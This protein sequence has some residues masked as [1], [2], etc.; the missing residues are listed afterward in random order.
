MW[1]VLV[2]DCFVRCGFF[3]FLV[4]GVAFVGFGLVWVFGGCLGFFG[5]F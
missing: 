5:G 3:L 4:V 2:E 1:L